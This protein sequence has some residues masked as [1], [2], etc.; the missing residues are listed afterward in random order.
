MFLEVAQE[1]VKSICMLQGQHVLY[2]AEQQL[3][4][5]T[6]KAEQWI[7]ALCTIN[8]WQNNSPEHFLPPPTQS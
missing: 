8:S 2:Q 5:P 4:E 3:S 1:K 6:Q 7:P